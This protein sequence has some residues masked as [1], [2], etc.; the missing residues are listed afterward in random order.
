VKVDAY[1]SG[2]LGEAELVA[3]QARAAGYDGLWSAELNHD[4]F[5]PLARAATA[6][7]PMQLGTSIVV[8]FARSPMTLAGTA[9]DLQELSG[10]RFLLGLGS[11]V[12]AHIQRRFSMPWSQPAARMREFIL[13]LG[14]I[15]DSWQNGT[16]LDFQGD[17]YSHTLMTPAFAPRP[18][19]GGPPRVLLAAV[20]TGMTRVAAEVADGLLA[21]SFTT[22]RYLREVTLPAIDAGLAKSGRSRDQ[23][24]VKYGP[25]VVTGADVAEMKRSADEARERIAFYASTPAYR[26]VLELHGWGDLQRDLNAMARRG[27]WQQMGGLIDDEMLAAFAVIAPRNELP[28]A[29]GQWVQGLAD[30]TSFTP[31]PADSSEQTS[32]MIAGL[33]SAAGDDGTDNGTPGGSAS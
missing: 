27:E 3:A 28:A 30:R 6:A 14:A 26:P 33:R 13:A 32:E 10:G 20:G 31:A 17:F 18:L 19:P 1:L 8:A 12:R 25:F 9:W 7:L 2:G 22:Q 5:L 24:E 11:Q 16:K 15:W 29:I 4:P 23:F 21:H